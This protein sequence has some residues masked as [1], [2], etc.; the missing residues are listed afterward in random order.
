LIADILAHGGRN[1]RALG[2]C[3]EGAGRLIYENSR[4]DAPERMVIE[5]H[6]YVV[7]SGKD[8]GEETRGWVIET[9]TRV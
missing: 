3:E 9:W 4:V 1:F 2:K 5:R 7:P 6:V 8:Y